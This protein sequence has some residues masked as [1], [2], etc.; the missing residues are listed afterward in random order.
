[1]CQNDGKNVDK[2]L[3]NDQTDLSD[4][5]QKSS[6]NFKKLLSSKG[7]IL[8]EFALAIPILIAILYYV[9]DIPKYARMK[10]RMEF[11]AH[12]AVNMIQN[13]SQNRE[14]KLITINDIKNACASAHLTVYR[15]NTVYDPNRKV[16][17]NVPW[18]HCFVYYI[19][20][21][22]DEK[23]SVLWL[24][25]VWITGGNRSVRAPR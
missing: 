6:A 2:L 12:C 8:I 21:M 3:A 18:V 13:V 4:V 11:C 16:D 19:K 5:Q 17:G 7:V 22:S 10:E 23:A 25:T 9:H 15:G 1:N 24:G 14:N 20:G